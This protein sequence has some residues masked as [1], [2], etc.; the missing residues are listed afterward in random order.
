[1][2]R[3]ERKGKREMTI[4]FGGYAKTREASAYLY[5]VQFE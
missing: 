3:G 2:K 1:M 5:I 4:E